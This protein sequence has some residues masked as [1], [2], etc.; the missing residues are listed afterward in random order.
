[1]HCFRIFKFILVFISV[2]IYFL[3]DPLIFIFFF[4]FCFIVWIDTMIKCNKTRNWNWNW[5]SIARIWCCIFCFLI[6]WCFWVDNYT[7]WVWFFNRG[8]RTVLRNCINLVRV[9]G[10]RSTGSHIALIDSTHYYRTH[11][12]IKHFWKGGIHWF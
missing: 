9:R 2:L 10:Q 8:I 11:T 6:R 7:E 1:M 3:I 5:S 12:Y 4:M